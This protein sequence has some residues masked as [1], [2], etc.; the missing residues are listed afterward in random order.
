[1]TALS[2]N[3][4]GKL[5]STIIENCIIGMFKIIAANDHI[6][7]DFV[8]SSIRNNLPNSHTPECLD[9]TGEFYRPTRSYTYGQRSNTEALQPISGVWQRGNESPQLFN[10]FLDYFLCIYKQMN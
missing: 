4:P 2:S 7:R 3:S 6:N 5:P 10:H 1:M 9:L 8:F